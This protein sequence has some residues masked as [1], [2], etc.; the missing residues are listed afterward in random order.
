MA[1]YDVNLSKEQEMKK[2]SKQLQQYV[3]Q[4]ADISDEIADIHS[5]NAGKGKLEKALKEVDHELLGDG[6]ELADKAKRKL[7]K[8]V[9][10]LDKAMRKVND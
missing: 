7:L 4:L 6:I 5:K 3:D 9:D 1:I 2:F 8:Y 10:S